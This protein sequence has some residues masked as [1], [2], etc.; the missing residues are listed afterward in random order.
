MNKVS[1]FVSAKVM[2]EAE[3]VKLTPSQAYTDSI[4]KDFDY[5]D[6]TQKT[7]K[8]TNYCSVPFSILSETTLF[9]D[10]VG[11]GNFSAKIKAFT[12]QAN[13]TINVPVYYNGMYKGTS[14][15]PAYTISVNGIS[16]MYNLTVTVPVV[17]QPPV[18][19]DILKVLGN[20]VNYTLTIA[21]FL[22]HFTDL[23]ND[24][25]DA[26]IIEGD[27]SSYRLNGAILA[28]GTVIPRA[29]I[30]NGLLQKLAPNTNSYTD[31]TTVWKAR[32]TA[33]QTS[34]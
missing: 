9:T 17:N 34:L 31:E 28:S 13:Q 4:I 32:D 15:S 24:D 16:N 27:T 6:V 33:G 26:V 10:T 11:G 14:L 3:C 7:I 8:I 1:M 2:T 29:S 19:T 21:D 22:A 30:E 18:V 5:A 25:L 12:I 20:R 23:D